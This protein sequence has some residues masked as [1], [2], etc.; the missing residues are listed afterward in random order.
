[1]NETPIERATRE[2]KEDLELVHS[3]QADF[4]ER[5]GLSEAP[6]DDVVLLTLQKEG[7]DRCILAMQILASKF[8]EGRIEDL[9]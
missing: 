1:M 9:L 3:I 6:S 8:V 5:T 7:K 4:M 2:A